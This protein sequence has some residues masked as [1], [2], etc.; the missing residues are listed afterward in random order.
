MDKKRNF[1]KKALRD[2]ELIDLAIKYND[3]SAFSELMYNYKNT[4]YFTIL[5]KLQITHILLIKHLKMLFYSL[6]INQKKL[7]LLLKK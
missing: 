1:S 7:N 6:K 2:F 5:K 3:Q 4:I